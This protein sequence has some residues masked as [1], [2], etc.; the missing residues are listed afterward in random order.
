MKTILATILCLTTILFLGLF[1]KMLQLNDEIGIEN[2]F[3]QKDLSNY[4]TLIEAGTEEL[5]E[6][7]TEL[8]EYKTYFSVWDLSQRKRFYN[9]EA[10]NW[11][12]IIDE[13]DL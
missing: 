3:L 9:T 6:C 13:D 8:L 4:K 5:I 10:I 11:E 2:Y 7:K 1:L 12:N